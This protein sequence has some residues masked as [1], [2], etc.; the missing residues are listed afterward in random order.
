MSRGWRQQRG[1]A[2]VRPIGVR[3]CCVNASLAC[4]C[5]HSHGATA[6]AAAGVCS[7]WQFA[8]RGHSA[9]SAAQSRTCGWGDVMWWVSASKMSACVCLVVSKLLA[10]AAALLKVPDAHAHVLSALSMLCAVRPRSPVLPLRQ[11]CVA[12][13]WQRC[14]L[15]GFGLQPPA[16]VPHLAA[17]FRF[18]RPQTIRHECVHMCACY[19]ITCL[20]ITSAR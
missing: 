15:S 9:H 10:A 3:L 2:H 16:E 4:V 12:L 18:I 14:W 11:R 6:V 20:I 19:S 1:R 5:F 8:V 7:S 17:S 13:W